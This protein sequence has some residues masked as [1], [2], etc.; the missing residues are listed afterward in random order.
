MGAGPKLLL[1]SHSL[2]LLKGKR[3][4]ML[5]NVSSHVSYIKGVSIPSEPSEITPLTRE[6][7][8]TLGIFSAPLK[9]KIGN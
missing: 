2:T 8:T 1:A 7:E 9:L 3:Q 4:P 6:Y 5:L